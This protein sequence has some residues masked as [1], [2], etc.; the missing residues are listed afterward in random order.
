MEYIPSTSISED[1]SGGQAELEQDTED[2][3]TAQITDFA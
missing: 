1:Q 2:L 3:G